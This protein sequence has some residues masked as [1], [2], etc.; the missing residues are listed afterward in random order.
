MAPKR[1]TAGR[2]KIAQE[3]ESSTPDYG[4]MQHFTPHATLGLGPEPE[5]PQEGPAEVTGG[6]T[7]NK[8][9]EILQNLTERRAP[10]GED[11]ALE[12]FL[13]FQHP[14]FYGEADQDQKAEQW[15]EQM[16]DIF[17]TL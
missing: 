16:E 4:T 17:K 6:Q 2:T 12:R 10:Q 5:I 3:A 14:T 1:R 13:K 11:M 9:A 7:F 15:M 8:M